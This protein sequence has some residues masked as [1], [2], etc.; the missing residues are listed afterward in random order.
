MPVLVTCPRCGFQG[1]LPED[2]LGTVIGC[3]GCS[4]GFAAEETPA[5]ARPAHPQSIW[6][7]NPS[8]V[9]TPPPVGTLSR[10]VIGGAARPPE[11]TPENAPSQLAWVRQE[12]GRF[13]AYVAAQLDQLRARRD[14][15]GRLESDATEAFVRRDQELNL[16]AAALDARSAALDRR[17]D[18]LATSEASLDR[19]LAEAAELEERLR[20]EL[21]DQEAEVVRQRRAVDEAAR[22]ARGR[23]APDAELL[24][25]WTV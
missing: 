15:L 18:E 10:N 13:R 17:A 3:P 19:R 8:P 16:R 11:V 12:V 7:G 25:D 9:Q 1:Q 21:E 23:A 24:P 14:E 5:P 22:L 2:H 20:A 6:I 4:A